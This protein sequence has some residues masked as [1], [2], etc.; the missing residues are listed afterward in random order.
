[1]ESLRTPQGDENAP[2]QQDKVVDEGEWKKKWEQKKTS[3]HKD[4]VHRLLQAHLNSLLNN[5][6]G[7]RIFFPL[8]GKVVDMKWLADM[9]HMITGVDVSEIGL[10]G[11]FT[12]QN[13]P[14][15]EEDVPE[16]PGAKLFKSSSGNISLYC[17]S[18]YDFIRIPAKYDGI[19][20]RGSLVAI[21]PRDR[22]RYAKALLSLM[23][24]DCCYLLI[25]VSY[26]PDLIEGPPFYVPDSVIEKLYGESCTIKLLETVDALDDRTRGWGL[27]Y[28][29]ETI[30]LLTLKDNTA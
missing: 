28:F 6:T 3:F 9:G 7:L 5:R 20:D 2:R 29:W 14:Y 24:Q 1:M 22:E 30:H 15:V 16:I 26:N 10:K 8:C 27:D 21:N 13:I 25:T 23:E 19:W 12:E 18:F 4:H 11:F 17:C